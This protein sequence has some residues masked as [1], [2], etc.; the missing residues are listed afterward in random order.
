MAIVQSIVH[1]GRSLEMEVVAEGVETEAQIDT[2]RAAGC[3]HLQGYHLARP[4]PAE[5]A[6]LLAERR[7]VRASQPEVVG[8]VQ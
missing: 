1:L 3:S 8:S 6:L 2:L 4:M 7:F 5:D